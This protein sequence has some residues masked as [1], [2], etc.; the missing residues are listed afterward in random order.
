MDA[1]YVQIA[2]EAAIGGVHRILLKIK[3]YA[4]HLSIPSLL[5]S[6]HC[7]IAK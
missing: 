4:F 1:S 5:A 2:I 6:P 7:S 3:H